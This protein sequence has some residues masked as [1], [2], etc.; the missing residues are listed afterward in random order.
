MPVLLA[1]FEAP[2]DNGFEEQNLFRLATGFD[3][4]NNT[5]RESMPS[6]YELRNY[7]QDALQK[8]GLFPLAMQ[9]S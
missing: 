4:Q 6:V 7:G 5:V 2:A 9:S 8:S 3:L 1:R